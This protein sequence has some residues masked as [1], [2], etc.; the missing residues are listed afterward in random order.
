MSPAIERPRAC[1]RS[2]PSGTA[3]ES[4]P[5]MMSCSVTIIAS[6]FRRGSRS[7]ASEDGAQ[8]TLKIWM[9]AGSNTTTNTAGKMHTA[10]GNNILIGAF[11]DSSC[12][13]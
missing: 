3:A 2:A 8:K 6:A 4:R 11:C 7:R 10:S 5:T 12:A 13:A 9:T 1:A